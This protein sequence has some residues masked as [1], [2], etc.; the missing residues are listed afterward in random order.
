MQ[1]IV[2]E[3]PAGPQVIGDPAIG[4]HVLVIEVE[5][6]QGRWRWLLPGQVVY[7]AVFEQVT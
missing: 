7:V 1:G 6:I 2:F 3:V 4:R 5:E